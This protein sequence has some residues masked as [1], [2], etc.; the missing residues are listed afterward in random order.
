MAF[1]RNKNSAFSLIE[2]LQTV[3]LIGIIAGLSISFFRSVNTD[4]KLRDSTEIMLYQ[5]IQEANRQMCSDTT[6]FCRIAAGQGYIIDQAAMNNN[7][8]N[9]PNGNLQNGFCVSARP[10]DGNCPA[11]T[12]EYT[13][14]NGTVNCYSMPQ[15]NGGAQAVPIHE[16][17][18]PN[19]IPQWNALIQRNNAFPNVNQNLAVGAVPNNVVS[20]IC[21]RLWDLINHRRQGESIEDDLIATCVTV[22][23]S[24]FATNNANRPCSEQGNA[25][26]TNMILPNG[27]RLYNLSGLA[28]DDR[29]TAATP[30]GQHIY[31]KY[32]RN[33]LISTHD[34]DNT[35]SIFNAVWF[36]QP[37]N[38]FTAAG[39]PTIQGG[40]RGQNANPFIPSSVQMLLR[41]DGIIDNNNEPIYLNQQAQ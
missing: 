41:T 3:V 27:V 39:A 28:N 29:P 40:S 5:A 25:T 12:E 38:L 21:Y 23:N 11:D 8:A 34:L 4:T 36:G 30:D 35:S 6:L 13:E 33:P 32:D 9:C 19:G 2:I 10:N 18:C 17:I 20:E 26:G 31:I 14:R 1:I 15:C 22:V 16:Q 37:N 24:C 7:M